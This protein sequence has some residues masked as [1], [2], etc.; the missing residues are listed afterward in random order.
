MIAS[1]SLD[2]CKPIQV[3]TN[4]QLIARQFQT[5]FIVEVQEMRNQLSAR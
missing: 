5:L 1:R 2:D 4:D 3:V